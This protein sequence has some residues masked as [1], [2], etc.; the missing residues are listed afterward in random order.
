MEKKY[1]LQTPYK[2]H[3]KPPRY[4]GTNSNEYFY[5]TLIQGMHNIWT[6]L[7]GKRWKLNLY[8]CSTIDALFDLNLMFTV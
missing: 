7:K 8:F 2:K 4:L 5:V 6:D 3:S 1:A